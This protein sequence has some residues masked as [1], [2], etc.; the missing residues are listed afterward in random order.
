MAKT[1]RVLFQKLMVIYLVRIFLVVYRTQMYVTLLTK[2]RHWYL[3][4]ASRMK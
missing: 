4:R 2:E 1:Q 3:C